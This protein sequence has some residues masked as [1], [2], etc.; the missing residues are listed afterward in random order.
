MALRGLPAKRAAAGVD[1]TRFYEDQLA[2]VV[3]LLYSLT[4]SWPVAEDLAQEAFLRAFRSWDGV[5]GLDRPDLWVRTVAVNLSAS[6]FR[7]MAAETRALGRLL[8]RRAPVS[9]ELPEDDE[10]FWAAVRRLPPRQ[11]H[12]IA[13]RY[14][15]DRSVAQIAEV[16]GCAEGTVKAHLSQGR[17]ALTRLLG[18]SVE[19]EPRA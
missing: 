14:A 9:E 16:M 13:L 7:R 15:D 3:A 6:R 11:A 12:A 4:G 5:R 8:A 18:L 17:A 2:G 19:E 10:R 1:F